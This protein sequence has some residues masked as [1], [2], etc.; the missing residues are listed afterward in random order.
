MGGFLL[1]L[2]KMP[3]W[4]AAAKDSHAAIAGIVLEVMIV[5]AL[6]TIVFKEV[7][8]KYGKRGD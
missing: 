8:G 4:V 5:A 3:V 2:V 6:F 1:R 7:M